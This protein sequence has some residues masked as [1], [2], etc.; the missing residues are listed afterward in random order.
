MRAATAAVGVLL[1][2]ACMR[3]LAVPPAPEAGS[4]SG[5]VVWAKPGMIQR[6]PAVGAVVSVFNSPN[7]TA[8]T[9]GGTFTLPGIDAP[10]LLHVRFDSDGDGAFDKERLLDLGGYGVGPHRKVDLGQIVLGEYASVR[11]RVLLGNMPASN[12]H[13][14]TTFFVPQGPYSALTNAEG[15]FL[16]P[17]LPEGPLSFMAFRAGYKTKVLGTVTLRPAEELNVGTL[18]LE[19]DPMA[20]TPGSIS[21]QLVLRPMAPKGDCAVALVPPMAVGM[22]GDEVDGGYP[23]SFINVPSGIYVL[24]ASRTGYFG[25]PQRNVVV[26]PGIRTELGDVDLTDM[27]PV[28][29]NAGGAGGGSGTAGGSAAGGTGGGGAGGGT[30]GG[31]GPVC[32]STSDCGDAGWC[33]QGSCAPP[34]SLTSACALGRTCDPAT[35]T[36]VASCSGSCP[37]GTNCDTASG[38]CRDRCDITGMCRPGFGCSPQGLCLPQCDVRSPRCPPRTVCLYGQCVSDRTCATDLD[39]GDEGEWC[40]SGRCVARRTSRVDGGAFA[41]ATACDCRLGEWCDPAGECADDPPPTMKLQADGGVNVWV[42]INDAGA[43]QVIALRSTDVFYSNVPFRFGNSAHRTRL[44][45]GYV[46]CTPERWVRSSV[47]RSTLAVDGGQVLFV[48]GFAGAPV[49]D[50]AVQNLVLENRPPATGCPAQLEVWYASRPTLR[51]IDGRFQQ[52]TC[53]TTTQVLLFLNTIPG[54]TVDGVT[55]LPSGQTL[56]LILGVEFFSSPD[57]TVRNVRLAPQPGPLHDVQLVYGRSTA[58]GQVTVSG[59]YL[60]PITSTGWVNPIYLNQVYGSVVVENNV[61]FWPSGTVASQYFTGISVFNADDAVLR[62]NVIDGTSQTGPLHPTAT[63]IELA[64]TGGRVTGNRILPPVSASPAN[65][66]TAIEASGRD[67]RLDIDG[68]VIAGGMTGDTF[69]GINLVNQGLGGSLLVAR[70]LI[71]G[72]AAAT[73]HGIAISNTLVSTGLRVEENDVMVSGRGGCTGQVT[74]ALLL[75]V[76]D[77][78]RVERN[79]F[80]AANA[81]TVAAVNLRNGGAV[82]LYGNHLWAGPNSCTTPDPLSSGLRL[83]GQTAYLGGNTIE[84]EGSPLMPGDSEAITCEGV[85]PVIFAESNVI[86]AG[87]AATHRLLANDSNAVRCFDGGTWTNNYFWYRRPTMEPL[88]AGDRLSQVVDAGVGVFDGRGNLFAGNVSPFDAVQP[89]RPDGGT[90]HDFRL[91]ALSQCIDR[92]VL[93]VRR[94]DATVVELDLLGATRDAGLGPDIGCCERM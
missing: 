38:L 74:D 49:N 58:P 46:A 36:C 60:P 93:S 73:M 91:A 80:S 41:C 78:V 86:G 16:L 1:A 79:R 5:T 29:P 40:E 14:G 51:F 7:Q 27:M 82:E 44:G 22:V 88:A 9:M 30:A 63:G 61:F 23:F 39:C 25:V 43:D 3:D 31:N 20:A 54:A 26:L 11:G 47:S 90:L 48:A 69:Y 17:N 12:V 94:S 28:M 57:T 71:Y 84:A 50:P 67:G 21:G 32:A 33:D 24:N 62:N 75:T 64:N 34:C 76:A 10:E 77:G 18:T 42:A 65:D 37:F 55:I 4:V 53:G 68:N 66:V 19:P 85:G 2:A 89:R 72:H 83:A 52:A 15:D 45:G 8:T 56:G 13:S 6:Q 59:L 87:S 35:S 70:N 92:G 81:P